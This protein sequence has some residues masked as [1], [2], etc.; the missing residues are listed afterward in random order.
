[1][2]FR[3]LIKLLLE[4]AIYISAFG[5]TDYYM[6]VLDIQPLRFYLPLFIGSIFLINWLEK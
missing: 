2:K 1:M 6:D 5:I 3:N 4:V